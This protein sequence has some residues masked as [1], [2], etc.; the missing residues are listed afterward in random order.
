LE[1]NDYV[2]SLNEQ[3]SYLIVY[4]R[5]IN[6][7]DMAGALFQESRGM[8]DAG[9]TTTITAYEVF[10]EMRVLGA[11]TEPLTTAEYR[12]LLCLYVQLAEAGGVYEVLLNLMGVIQLKPYNLWPFQD[13]VRVRQQ[14]RRV[15]GPN[16]NAMFQRLAESANA[17]G[18]AKLATLL[19]I[20]F[21]DDI[22]NGISHADYIIHHDGLRLR[23]RNGGNPFTIAHEDVMKAVNIG[24]MFFE[25]FDQVQQHARRSFR[26]ARHIVGRFSA[27]PPMQH[28]VEF[29]EDGRFSISTRSP[30]PQT[31]AAYDRQQHINNRLGGRLFA[32]YV[33]QISDSV[34]RLLD[35]VLR[36]GFDVLL[37]SLESDQ[38]MEQFEV[39]VEQYGLW[40]HDVAGDVGRDGLLVA[41]PLGFRRVLDLASFR[42]FLPQV[43]ELE[44]A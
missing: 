15:I 27:N 12:Q 7:L 30:G 2:R 34:S 25:L 13:L 5:A 42:A 32:A 10:G 8:Q 29:H 36:A 40:A 17:I 37:I 38:R 39:D 14:P 3:L 9:W 33:V 22:R 18:M 23:R 31:D 24:L 11:K 16:A 21:R 44:I 26:P 41:T 35:E 43:D 1:P 20:A 28:T 6:E 4:T 19:E